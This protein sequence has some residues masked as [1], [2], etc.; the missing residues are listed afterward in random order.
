VKATKQAQTILPNFQAM[1]VIPLLLKSPH[2]C[3]RS[4]ARSWG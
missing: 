1:L 3:S 2:K 4:H